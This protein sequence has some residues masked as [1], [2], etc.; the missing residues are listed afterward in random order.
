LKSWN[1]DDLNAQQMANYV[2]VQ[3]LLEAEYERGF[4]RGLEV[5]HMEAKTEK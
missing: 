1:P 4:R 2:F 5:G 3:G